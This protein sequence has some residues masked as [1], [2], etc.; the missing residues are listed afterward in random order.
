MSIDIDSIRELD[1]WIFENHVFYDGTIEII[2]TM[3]YGDN[4]TY[5]EI[6]Y[7]IVD[8]NDK[9]WIAHSQIRKES[10]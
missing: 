7:V 6:A 3:R 8:E 9:R 1:K 2:A 10:K 5:T 4:L